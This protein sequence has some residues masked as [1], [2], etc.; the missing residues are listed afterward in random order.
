MR[1]ILDLSGRCVL[2]HATTDMTDMIDSRRHEPMLQSKAMAEIRVQLDVQ[3]VQPDSPVRV[4]QACVSRPER[5]RHGEA[6]A[7]GRSI[8]YTVRVAS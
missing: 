8:Q 6:A 4:S 3:R 2:L 5:V 7:R 1:M